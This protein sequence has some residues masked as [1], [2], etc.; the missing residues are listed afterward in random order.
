MSARVTHEPVRLRV[1]HT[2]ATHDARTDEF[3]AYRTY[4]YEKG[5][6]RYVMNRCDGTVMEC[7]A[8]EPGV[9]VLS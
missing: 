8:D 6:T 9:E 2:C 7:W 5:G 3:T 1:L 4:R